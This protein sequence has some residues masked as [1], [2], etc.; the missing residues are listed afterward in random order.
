ML[1]KKD[2]NERIVIF[3][4]MLGQMD[5]W[6]RELGL[7]NDYNRTIKRSVYSLIPL[8]GKSHLC[9]LVTKQTRKQFAQIG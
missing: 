5:A 1:S 4:K 8:V 3:T 9:P 2:K 7:I 6:F